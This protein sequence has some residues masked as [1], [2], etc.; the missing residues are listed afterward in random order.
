MKVTQTVIGNVLH[1]FATFSTLNY[2][3]KMFL[4]LSG[5]TIKTISAFHLFIYFKIIQNL[6]VRG[7]GTDTTGLH[8]LT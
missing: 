1:C 6:I 2:S 8:V 7:G 3:S 5:P 4:S